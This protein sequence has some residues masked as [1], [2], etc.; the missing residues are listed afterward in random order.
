MM[1]YSQA[2][3]VIEDERGEL[4][5]DDDPELYVALTIAIEAIKWRRA[6]TGLK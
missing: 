4:D 3:E 2:I 1:T 6:Y 5:P